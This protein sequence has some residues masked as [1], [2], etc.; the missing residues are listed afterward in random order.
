MANGTHAGGRFA[1]AIHG[2]GLTIAA[3]LAL[4]AIY[5][6]LEGQYTRP[7]LI[8]AAVLLV[9]AVIV[10]ATSPLAGRLP[11]AFDSPAGRT[12]AWLI[13]AAMLGVLAFACWNFVAKLDDMENLVVSFSTWDQVSALLAILV[14]LELTRRAFGPILASV[15]VIALVYC[16]FGADLPWIF[17][18]SGFSLELSMEIIWFGLRGVFG[19]ATGIVVLLILVFIVFG[20]LLEG[21]GAG[22]VMIRMAL[23]ATGRTRGGPAHAAIIASS[24]FGMSSGSVTANVVGTG[25]VTIPLIKR[26]G[27]KGPFAG[28]VEA[29]ASTGGQ[30]MPPVMGAAAFLMTQLAGQ[31]YQL[32]ALAALVPALF[33]YGSLFVAV[34]QEAR[35]LG[36]EP[37]PPD[38]RQKLEPGDKL[39][40]L[41]FFLPVAAII[42]VLALGRSPSMA[43]FWACIVTIVSAFALNPALR[44]DPMMLLKA[45]AKGG[46]AGAR[47]M[48]AVGAIGV[49]IAVFELTG[50]GLKFATQVALIGE[51]TLFMALV[52]AAAS[53]LV[54]GMGMPTLPAYLIIV[55]VL[56]LGMKKLGLP[57][58]AIHMFVFYFGV[59]SAITPPVA[60]AAV[61]AA[62]IAGAEPVRTGLA[63]LR[64]S[65]VGF[66]VPFV[67]VYEPSLL[68]VVDGFTWQAFIWIALRLAFAVWLLTSAA[69][70][71]ELHKLA[72]WSRLARFSAGIA[73]L[74]P[75]APVH[76]AAVGVGIAVILV[77]RAIA[78]RNR[79]AG[80]TNEV[81]EEKAAS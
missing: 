33:Y 43:G 16:L 42:T 40:S 26:K 19:F 80:G 45:L 17:R 71:Y 64:L 2:I 65:M 53:C 30:L 44:E 37:T 31:P 28:A 58:L 18:H 70:G 20:A 21:T 8:R 74:V 50:L 57:D 46:V 38:K 81:L 48:M 4:H 60:L 67:F 59:L 63:A 56:G 69:S 78:R 79:Q 14:L 77:D 3:A 27:F 49:L 22:A 32:I 34:G 6:A 52:L 1:S 10:V 24:V 54:L 75:V 15:G 23:A 47:I 66:I 29:A 51:T 5:V 7:E 12:L 35:R 73:I 72:A 25:V 68:L 9:C 55:L 62:P 39:K 11:A 36:I 13:D 76:L 61:A 41:M